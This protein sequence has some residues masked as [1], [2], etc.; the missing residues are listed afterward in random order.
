MDHGVVYDLL[1]QLRTGLIQ[2]EELTRPEL[3]ELLALG[4]EHPEVVPAEVGARMLTARDRSIERAFT[5]FSGQIQS[6]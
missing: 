3:E 6:G 1:D 4:R 5:P 2:A